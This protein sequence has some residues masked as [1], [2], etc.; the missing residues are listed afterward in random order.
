MVVFISCK[1]VIIYK[2]KKVKIVT[3]HMLPF[4]SLGSD[5]S[6]YGYL[7]KEMYSKVK[8]FCN[9]FPFVLCGDFNSSKL[10][11]VIK[12]ISVDML[13]VFTGATRYNGNQNDYIFTSKEWLCKNYRVDMNK[14]DHFLCV[15]ELELKSKADLNILHISDIH[16]L[17]KDYSIDE[18]T[19]LP[20]VRESDIRKRLFLEKITAFSEKINYVIVSGDITT[21]G[22]K[23]GFLEFNKFVTPLYKFLRKKYRT[24]LSVV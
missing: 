6:Q 21:G 7:Y 22:K 15:C 9:G 14:Y 10:E 4:H 1:V 13:K 2:G 3:G 12:E 24:G 18:K 8:T 19:R 5:S 17:S 11:S 16:Y 20:K 23:E